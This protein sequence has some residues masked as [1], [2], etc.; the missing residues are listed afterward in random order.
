VSDICVSC[1]GSYPVNG[2]IFCN[3]C[4]VGQEIIEAAPDQG[5]ADWFK[6]AVKSGH[7]IIMS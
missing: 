2:S 1:S 5:S 6:A 3:E 4:K 7:I